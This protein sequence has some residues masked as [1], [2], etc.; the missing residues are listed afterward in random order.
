MESEEKMSI[1]VGKMMEMGGKTKNET[2][3]EPK[4]VRNG[5]VLA[6]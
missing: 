6:Y 3:P 1:F 2:D 5:H 4:K